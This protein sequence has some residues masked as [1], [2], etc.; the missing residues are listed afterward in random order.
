[1]LTIYWI[2][3]WRV[4]AQGGLYGPPAF[5]DMLGC[6]CHRTSETTAQTGIYSVQNLRGTIFSTNFLVKTFSYSWYCFNFLVCHFRPRFQNHPGYSLGLGAAA[7]SQLKP[8]GMTWSHTGPVQSVVSPYNI[9]RFFQGASVTPLGPVESKPHG[10]PQN[11]G[12]RGSSYVGDH[13]WYTWRLPERLV[14]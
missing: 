12:Q 4:D 2:S 11:M 6:Q 9:A 1:M 14:P 13:G 7:F 3:G 10:D 8:K 5:Q